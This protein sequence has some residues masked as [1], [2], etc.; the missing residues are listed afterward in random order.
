MKSVYALLVL[1]LACSPTS[2]APP[3]PSAPDA[4]LEAKVASPAPWTPARARASRPPR[5]SKT[6]PKTF[7][8]PFVPTAPPSWSVPNWYVDNANSTGCAKDSNSGT[9]ASCAAG[10]VGP[11]KT[12]NGGL[13][14]RWGCGAGQYG[15][16]VLAQ[17]TTITW[18]SDDA[19]TD[20]A[21]FRGFIANGGSL[22]A[23]GTL[24]A[25]TW[26]SST[27]GTVTAKNP[28]TSTLLKANLGQ[29]VA[30]VVGYLVQNTN[31]AHPS[32]AW[33]DS[34][35]T[36]VATFTQPF[37]SNTPAAPTFPVAPVS[38]VEVNAWTTGDHFVIYRPTQVYL[39]NWQPVSLTSDVSFGSAFSFIYHIWAPDL[40]GGAD[41][42][43]LDNTDYMVESRS[44][45]WVLMDGNLQIAASN[46][47][48]IA[49]SWISGGGAFNGGGSIVG[50]A[51]ST[52][53]LY[54]QYFSDG[55]EVFDDTILHATT[56]TEGF[57][58]LDNVYSDTAISATGGTVDFIGTIY[59]TYTVYTYASADVSY[60]T[61]AT[62]T[63]LGSPTLY[64]GG[65][66][67]KGCS[68]SSSE[69]DGGPTVVVISCGI[70]LTTTKLDL[71][72][73][74]PGTGFGGSAFNLNNGSHYF[75]NTE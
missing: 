12:Y 31:V 70:S 57:Q 53:G 11:F 32:F 2:S 15:C 25:Q 36:N 45:N 74:G 65:S 47:F 29:A 72:N 17:P 7:T 71:A 51:F 66:D 68:A 73:T 24:V 75:L 67:T 69:T 27:L 54:A 18:L 60:G 1:L 50:G 34:A 42:L 38:M 23:V 37:V 22:Y 28:A 48:G 33:I 63:F 64:F 46:G 35:A 58:V 8:A 6:P 39:R 10:G 59:G 9:S 40:N 20:I 14:A 21:N 26:G 41:P 4:S 49:N 55:P 43:Y 3:A 52:L 16:P 19:S 30:P 61:S 56:Y 5:L 62:A 13:M 44:D